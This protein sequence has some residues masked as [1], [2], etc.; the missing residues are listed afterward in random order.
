MPKSRRDGETGLFSKTPGSGDYNPEV[1]M[2]LV[3]P[4]TAEWKVGSE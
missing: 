2:K 4:K 3:K 1:S